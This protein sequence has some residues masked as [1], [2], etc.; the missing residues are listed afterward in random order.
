MKQ[1]EIAEISYFIDGGSLL[2]RIL[3]KRD[4][5]FTVICESHVLLYVKVHEPHHRG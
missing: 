1:P 3:W 4:E 2:Q 5:T